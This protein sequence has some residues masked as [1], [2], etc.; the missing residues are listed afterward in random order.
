VVDCTTH[1][2][3]WT[4]YAQVLAQAAEHGH[5]NICQLMLDSGQVTDCAISLALDAACMTQSTVNSATA[6]TT[7]S[8]QH[9]R[10]D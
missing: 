3:S 4:R 10:L 7:R 2:T 1:Q 8:H 5:D 6:G 9:T